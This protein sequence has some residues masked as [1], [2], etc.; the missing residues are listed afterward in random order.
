M[1]AVASISNT[2]AQQRSEARMAQMLKRFPEADAN[3]DGKLSLKEFQAANQLAQAAAARAIPTFDPGWDENVFP[4]HAVSLKTPEEIKAIYERGK[5]A[6]TF[7]V[8][9]GLPRS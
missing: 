1:M 3:G 4:S 8:R 6:R 5:P 9:A 2:Q 7:V